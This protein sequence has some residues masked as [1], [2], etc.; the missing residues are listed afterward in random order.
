LQIGH[1]AD[2]ATD[3]R[4]MLN[5][6]AIVFGSR[7]PD[8]VNL[9]SYISGVQEFSQRY[10]FEPIVNSIFAYLLKNAT[11]FDKPDTGKGF[12]VSDIV[13]QTIHGHLEHLDKLGVLSA[14]ATRNTQVNGKKF[15][16]IKPLAQFD[17]PLVKRLM[18][19]I[20]EEKMEFMSFTY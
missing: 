6:L 15:I 17:H 12:L 20:R 16:G 11:L 3:I 2:N 10:K 8:K 4:E 14:R 19:G 5:G 1:D 13:A 7:L 9:D 18:S